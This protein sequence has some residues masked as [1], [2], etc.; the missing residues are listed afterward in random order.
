MVSLLFAE[1]MASNMISMVPCPCMFCHG[2]LVSIYVRR[3]HAKK[4]FSLSQL[5]VGDSRSDND[6]EK[7]HLTSMKCNDSNVGTSDATQSQVIT[8]AS[9]LHL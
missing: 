8:D 4:F 3:Q 7:T 9:Y 2:K 6:M 5:R 1:V